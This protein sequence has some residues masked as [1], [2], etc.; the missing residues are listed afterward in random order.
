MTHTTS[1]LSSRGIGKRYHGSSLTEYPHN[2]AKVLLE[3]FD[4]LG[5]AHYKAGKGLLIYGANAE[6]YDISV[7]QAR[8]LI[9]V[10]KSKM[11]CMDFYHLLESDILDQMWVDKPP[12][13]ITNYA[14][15]SHTLNSEG[16]SRFE[17]LAHRYIDNNIP[18]TFHLPF[19]KDDELSYFRPVLFDRLNKTNYKFYVS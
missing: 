19:A 14:P 4:E 10:N 17:L 7:L 6:A 1:L 15:T 5:E 11:L 2:T 16:Y 18:I 12:L 3:W 9:L 8:M 13:T